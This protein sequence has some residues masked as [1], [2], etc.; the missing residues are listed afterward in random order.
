MSGPHTQL[1]HKGIWHAN[2]RF[3]AVVLSPGSPST[4]SVKGVDDQETRVT[5]RNECDGGGRHG[6][7][8][9]RGNRQT[10]LST[11]EKTWASIRKTTSRARTRYPNS[12]ALKK[13]HHLGQEKKRIRSICVNQRGRHSAACAEKRQT[14]HLSNSE[15]QGAYPRLWVECA[16]GLPWGRKRT[17]KGKGKKIRPM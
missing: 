11:L 3:L 13:L 9:V 12:T 15:K 5:T 10:G 1:N 16:Q 8:S 4:L 6:W 2:I 17:R 7:Y 14:G